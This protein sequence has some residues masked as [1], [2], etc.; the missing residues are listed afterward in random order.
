MQLL[1]AFVLANVFSTM[2]K[3]YWDVVKDCGLF[4]FSKDVRCK[5]LRKDIVFNPLLYYLAIILNLF[6]RF[7]WVVLFAVRFTSNTRLDMQ[8]FLFLVAFAGIFR[9]FIW[10][11]FR[12]ENEHLNNCDKFR[13]VLD[14]PLPFQAPQEDQKKETVKKQSFFARWGV[15]KDSPFNRSSNT[16]SAI[17]LKYMQLLPS[18]IDTKRVKPL[19]TSETSSS[20]ISKSKSDSFLSRIRKSPSMPLFTKKS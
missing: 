20:K 1:E 14:I 6:M 11:I 10:N 15:F 18:P 5:G 3:C 12:L 7:M 2:Y 16:N 9:R 4:R 19:E 8:Y 13:A 17:S